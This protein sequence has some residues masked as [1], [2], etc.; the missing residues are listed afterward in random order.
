MKMIIKALLP[1]SLLLVLVVSPAGAASYGYPGY[2]YNV[3][4]FTSFSPTYQSYSP[5]PISPAS[6]S[7]S[8]STFQTAACYY[9][10]SCGSTVPGTSTTTQGVAS[11]FTPTPTTTTSSLGVTSYYSTY[12]M[13]MFT[14]TG[15]GGTPMPTFGGGLTPT[16][17]LGDPLANPEPTSIA[18]FGAGLFALG[19]ARR[20]RMSAKQ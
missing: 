13:Y 15:F 8:G 11:S 2:G 16:N 17:V 18:L 12:S 1:A 6:T 10:Y 4:G 9:T 14:P 3:F 7:P 19:W 20:R 5:A